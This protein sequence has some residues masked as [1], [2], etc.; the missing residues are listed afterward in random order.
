MQVHERLGGRFG[1]RRRSGV[2]AK[3]GDGEPVGER[4]WARG[5]DSEEAEEVEEDGGATVDGEGEVEPPS[6]EG[7]RERGPARLDSKV[8][9]SGISKL[10]LR[11]FV[12]EREFSSKMRPSLL[13]GERGV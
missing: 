9:D 1:V 6:G 12:R 8:G 10:G 11:E 3:P 13:M 7:A 5:V 4:V 2:G